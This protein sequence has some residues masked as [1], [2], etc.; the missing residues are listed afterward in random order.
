M[1]AVLKVSRIARATSAW[2]SIQAAA[3]VGETCPEGIG[4]ER[5]RSTAASIL[6][7]V[8]SFQVQPAPRIRKAPSAL[9]TKIHRSL[10][11]AR[12]SHSI[13]SASPIQ[14]GSSKSQVPMGRSARD[15]RR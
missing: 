1:A 6:R 8:M 14:Q 2:A 5:V 9:A 15:R 7:S 10:S 3:C 13:A 12:P 11:P 4:R